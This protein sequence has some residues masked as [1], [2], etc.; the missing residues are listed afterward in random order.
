MRTGR[1]YKMDKT[2]NKECIVKNYQELL[3]HGQRKIREAALE[4]IQAGIKGANPG[5]GTYEAVKLSGNKLLVGKKEYD[6]R[7]INHIYVVGA[8]KGALSIA[9]SLEKILGAYIHKG[10]VAAKKGDKRRLKRIEVIEAGHPLPDENSVIGARKVLEIAKVAGEGDLVFAAITGGSSALATLPP[11]GLKLE[12]MQQLTDLL[13]KSGAPIR[14]INAVRKHLSQIGGGLLISQIQP[15]EAITLTLDTKAKDLPWPDMCL[16][17]PSTFQDAIDVLKYYELWDSVSPSIKDYLLEGT[18][19][20]EMETVKSFAG[21]KATMI[22]VASPARAC[23]AAAKQ[24]AELGY[25]PVILSTHIDGEANVIGKCL[26]GIVREIT[27]NKRPFTPPCALISGGEMTVKVVGNGGV[28]GPNQE[29]VLGFALELGS[30]DKVCCASVD[31]DGSDGPTDI[32]GGIVDGETVTRA[33]RSNINIAD[34]L[35]N[36]NSSAA[37][38]TLEDTIV[39]GHTGTN[40]VDLRVILIDD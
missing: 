7:H 22:G 24:A 16:P 28:G 14:D 15:A 5:V 32:A 9:E 4:I 37:L 2:P 8:G 13:L 10:I 30:R 21:M 31:T 23:E 39:T 19:R 12:E 25:S 17:D 36:H 35:K 18:H 3:S 11:E 38:K 6:L 40:I 20:P 34:F 26:A 33:K 27:E 1:E 29:F